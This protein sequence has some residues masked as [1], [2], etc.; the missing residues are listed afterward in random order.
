MKYQ[1]TNAPN[2]NGRIAILKSENWFKLK[3]PAMATNTTKKVRP[4]G[5][6]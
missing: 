3:S 6:E 4:V 1:E 2:K 5:N